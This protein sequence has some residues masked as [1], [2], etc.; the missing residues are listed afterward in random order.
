LGD[1]LQYAKQRAAG[2]L[3]K[4]V[5]L[6]AGRGVNYYRLE[7]EIPDVRI[8]ELNSPWLYQLQ[9][10]LL[11]GKGKLLDVGK[12]HFGMRT[13]KIDDQSEPKGKITFNG[14]QIR[15]R[16]A[17]TMGH[18]QQCVLKKDFDQLRDDILL[19]KICNM[20]FLRLA[21]RPVQKEV[22]EYCDM[23]G[24]M[25]QTD[26]PLFG[27]IHRSQYM[28]TLRQ[29]SVMTRFVRPHPS[30][31][32]ISY[33]NEHFPNSCN[34]PHRN[35]SRAELTDFF[36][37]ADMIVRQLHPDV[38]TK[39][40]DG[41]YDPPALGLPDRHCYSAWYN[42]QGVD[43]G[44]LHKG[45]WQ[46]T[47]PG[48][49][50]GCGEFGSEAL[51]PV[52]LMKK[53]YPK[54]WLKKDN[55]VW[56][57]NKI[58]DAQCGMFHYFFYDTPDSME[59]WVDASQN[60]QAW[61]TRF[62][63]EAFRRDNRMV[64]FAVHL[65]IDAFPAGWMKA[66]MDCQRQPKKAYFAYRNALAPLLVNIRTDRFGF[67]S[68]E[69]IKLEAWICNDLIEYDKSLKLHYQFEMDGKVFMAGQRKV[70][71]GSCR[72]KFQGFMKL[73]AP[74]VDERKK[75][76]ARIALINPKGT[77][78]S[79]TS[80]ELDVFP[81]STSKRT[82]NV[83]TLNRAKSTATRLCDE[84]GIVPKVIGKT[85]KDV[86]VILIDSFA[87]FENK[88]SIV[89]EAVANGTKAI[90]MNM[91]AGLYKIGP[92]AVEIKNSSFNSLHFASRKTGHDY[93]KGFEPNDFRCWYDPEQ[94]MI[95]PFLDKTFVADGFEPIL[96]SGNLNA[97]GQWTKAMAVG[98]K[99][100]GNGKICICQ[101]QLLGRT[102][103]NPPAKLFAKKLLAAENVG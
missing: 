46:F 68:N 94:D 100:H 42:G 84:L 40:A 79:D 74:K 24:L 71:I 44:R 58:K 29:V 97:Q 16:G 101:I 83:Y 53:F 63:S 14:R 9:V 11:D 98:Q 33:I 25:V 61:A 12:Q 4:P 37:M 77:V 56:T 54:S 76:T 55:G 43:I 66:I 3:G 6:K 48:W 60:Y 88:K 20:N 49:H 23:L 59:D 102:T 18:E 91:P 31:V 30:V 67:Y 1:D 85:T 81:K 80:V 82:G 57:P 89:L 39:P 52:P 5:E 90:F 7:F 87:A 2:I 92:D 45:Y 93:V 70:D 103:A 86:D 22:Y 10:R 62:M 19:A 38:M 13:F 95:T 47:T 72:S 32:L 28:E 35:I 27:V 51:D 15:L 64:S 34:K 73:K 50:Y 26:L 8:W 99:K 41:D 17:N 69:T 65:F 96:T 78:V 36:I 75:I 21:Q